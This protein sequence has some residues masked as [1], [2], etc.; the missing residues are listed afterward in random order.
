[1]VGVICA[2]LRKNHK[3][4]TGVGF[5]IGYSKNIGGGFY[6]SVKLENP[7]DSEKEIKDICHIIFA[8]FYEYMPIRKVSISCHGIIPKVGVQ[9]NLF[10]KV[11]TLVKIRQK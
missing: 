5:G 9:L 8:R 3:Q 6:H 7:T 2:R 4:C 1:M 11:D 10:D